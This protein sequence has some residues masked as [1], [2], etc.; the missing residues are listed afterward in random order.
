MINKIKKTFNQNTKQ[1]IAS[2]CRNIFFLK[3]TFHIERHNPYLLNHKFVRTI[4]ES[5]LNTP[6][7]IKSCTISAKRKHKLIKCNLIQ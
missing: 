6:V 4:V 5:Y 3:N 2:F 1:N 7:N